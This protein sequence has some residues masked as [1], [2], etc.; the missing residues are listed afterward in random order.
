[1]KQE[2]EEEKK[3]SEELARELEERQKREQELVDQLKAGKKSP[4]IIVIATPKDQS[5]VEVNIIQLN[6]VAEDET[7]LE[8]L[9]IYVNGKR[10]N[11]RQGRGIKITP[12]EEV[13]RLEFN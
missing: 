4:P 5:K 13:D 2:F 7:A 6:G 8:R 12:G 11:T 1:M 3:K 9:E 10:I